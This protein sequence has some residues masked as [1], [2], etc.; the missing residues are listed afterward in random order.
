M[1]DEEQQEEMVRT[2][3]LW[4]LLLPI[5]QPAYKFG[6]SVERQAYIRAYSM[7]TVDQEKPL[8]GI[9]RAALNKMLWA[10]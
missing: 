3:Y 10:R 9:S 7:T 8:A 1:I 2:K 4:Q 5:S 6:L